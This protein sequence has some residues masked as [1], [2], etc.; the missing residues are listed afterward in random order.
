MKILLLI[1]FLLTGTYIASTKPELKQVRALFF[2]AASEKTAAVKLAQ[3]M[4]TVDMEDAPV[5]ICYKGVAE[6]MQAKYAFNPF[7]KLSKFNKGKALI[8]E[9]IKMDPHNLEMRFLRFSIQTNL[10]SLLKYDQQI[11]DDKVFLL[12]KINNIQDKD[13]KLKVFTY[14][15]SSK[16]CTKEDLKKLR[17]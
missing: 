5:L 6:M 14:L 11:K 10:P 13:L 2:E 7:S 12:N 1:T 3:L 15:S 9:A 8:E 16:Y 4:S 17:K